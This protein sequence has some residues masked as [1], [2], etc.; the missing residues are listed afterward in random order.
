M[1]TNNSFIKLW[2]TPVLLGILSLA[3]LIAALV[4]DGI[5]DIVSWIALGIPVIVMIK[6]YFKPSAEG[7]KE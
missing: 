7:N 3:G 6:Y 2:G 4:G 5:W 1:S